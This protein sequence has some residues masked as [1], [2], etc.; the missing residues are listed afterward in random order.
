MD[1]TP[2]RLENNRILIVDDNEAIH[3]EIKKILNSPSTSP[4]DE[5][6]SQK[7][8]AAENIIIEYQ[9]DDAYQGEEAVVMVQKAET[10]NRQYALIFIDVR[11]PPGINGIETIERIWK[12]NPYIEV[13]IC[14][15]ISD[16]LW[17]EI[18]NK[19]GHSGHLLFVKKPF[20][21]REFKEIT[22]SLI[23]KSNINEKARSIIK[24]M[25][26]EMIERTKQL[27][28][29][30]SELKNDSQEK[31]NKYISSSDFP[32]RDSLTGLY[33]LFAVNM[34]LREIFEASR[35]HLFPVSVLIL[36]I[37]NF[38]ELNDLYGHESGDEILI[39]IAELL[40]GS[41]YVPGQSYDERDNIGNIRK[42]D[43]AGRY[44][45]DE[46]AIIM[47]FCPEESVKCAA[48]RIL[49]RIQAISLPSAPEA[50][51]MGNCGIAVLDKDA[52]CR[53]SKQILSL[54]DK[55]LYYAKSQGKNR[56]HI[57]KCE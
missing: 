51:I 41:P 33:N 11:M 56:F 12:I 37:G 54:A 53:N 39:K 47:P 52:E 44:G 5:L 40:K 49:Q 1:I 19:T 43:I 50:I 55:A 34:K 23:L 9:I 3:E 48:S 8:K 6:T 14:A 31:R 22:F 18:I 20:N 30:I 28:S 46:F 7:E 35:R 21:S 27:S 25:E 29:F 15:A 36:D 2:E 10:R 45:S 16:N 42:S 13:V 4:E 38:K 24:N 17:E 26:D 32:E 57:I